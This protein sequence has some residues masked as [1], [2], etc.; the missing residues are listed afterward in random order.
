MGILD[1]FTAEGRDFSE[2]GLQKGCFACS[3]PTNDADLVA[4]RHD[5]I[6][7]NRDDRGVIT[8]C[9]LL[10]LHDLL[11][12]VRDG[13]QNNRLH[14]RFIFWFLYFF[15]ALEH[16]DAALHARCRARFVAEPVDVGFLFLSF[17][18]LYFVVLALGLVAFFFFYHVGV[19][20][21]CVGM[22][23][24][25]G[26][27]DDFLARVIDESDIVGDRDDGFFPEAA[28]VLEKDDALD[29][30]MVRRFVEDE[31]IDFLDQEFRDLH[32]RLFTPGELHHGAVERGFVEAEIG[33]DPQLQIVEIVSVV[34]F[35]VF[36]DI[37]DLIAVLRIAFDIVQTVDSLG[38]VREDLEHFL[39]ERVFLVL[40]EEILG[41]IADPEVRSALYLSLIVVIDADEHLQKRRFPGTVL[42]DEGELVFPIDLQIRVIEEF[43][44][45]D[46]LREIGDLDQSRSDRRL[47]LE[48]K[49]WKGIDGAF[50]IRFSAGQSILD[51]E[52]FFE[53]FHE[54]LHLGLLF[55]LF[56]DGREKATAEEL[57]FLIREI[58]MCLAYPHY[59]IVQRGDGNRIIVAEHLGHK[60]PIEY[61]ISVIYKVGRGRN[62]SV[63]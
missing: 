36:L 38:D 31:D 51:V 57:D 56:G 44:M 23:F 46:R 22:E 20:V 41:E 52:L 15:H 45:A 55:D 27:F 26:D 2:Y 9:D 58:R 61:G 13:F 35:Q 63:I 30:Q 5:D 49:L 14:V 11:R 17:A 50:G 8:S 42:A 6:V 59:D 1:D 19:V 62:P 29:I 10:Q 47:R 37:P 28:E 43:G 40:P 48:E 34:A 60:S 32:L 18:L 53:V 21:A 33:E 25:V 3:I 12:E 39:P 24:F 7:G 4:L 54:P 16:L